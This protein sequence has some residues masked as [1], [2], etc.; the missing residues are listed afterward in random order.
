MPLDLDTF[1]VT[2][3]CMI[4]DLYRQAFAVQKPVRPGAK[5]VVS[6][7]EVLTLTILA[8][9][10]PQRNERAFLRFV[11]THWRRYFPRQLSQS[12]F[13]RRVHDLAGVLSQIGP[14][15]SQTLGP[16]AYEV[17]DGVPVP[18]MRR[19]RGKQRRLFRDEAAFGRGGSDK[20]WYY[21]V[22]LVVSI[23]QT[24][25]CSGFV[26][27]PANT[28]E[29]WLTEALLRWRTDPTAPS[30]TA[31]ELAAVLGAAHRNGGAR[32]GPSGPLGSRQAAGKPSGVPYLGDLGYRGEAWGQHWTQ[33]YGAKVLTTSDYA[34][35]PPAQRERATRWFHGIRQLVERTLGGLDGR[36]GLK[37]PRARTFRGLLARLAAKVAALNA[38]VIVNHHFEREPSAF[39]D[40][41]AL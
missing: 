7:S 20:D 5:P 35:L 10:H 26:F 3:Y 32:R 23:T 19:C 21:G 29:R 40:L 6:D 2:V 31:A 12:A 39:V 24:G 36:F 17:L 4:D 38:A 28:E 13:N 34:D 1:L 11:Q 8:Q 22:K 41:F 25:L 14:A 27:G 33:A 37:F 15:L 9:W 16:S 30:P 18:L